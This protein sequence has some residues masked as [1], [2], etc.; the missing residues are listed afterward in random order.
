[1]NVTVNGLDIAYA[2]KGAGRVL[3]FLHGWGSSKETFDTLM[4]ALAADFT[5]IAVDL[6]GFGYSDQPPAAWAVGDY[7]QFVKFFLHTLDVNDVHAFVAHSFGGRVCIKGI[8]S[9]KLSAQKVVLIGAAGIKHS[10]SF[11]NMLYAAVAKIGK[12]VFAIPGLNNYSASARRKLYE[13]ASSTDYLN[14][15]TMRKVFT[16]AINEDLK[17]LLSQIT[18]PALLIWGSEDDQTPLSDARIMQKDIPNVT[19]RLQQ[20]AGHFVHSEYPKKVTGWLKEFLA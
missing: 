14:A 2:Q 20:R 10:D 5:V 15:G 12:V 7:V 3:L 6:P 11:R 9:G 1:M 8:S 13:N 18:V 4:D 19:L 17:P 16:N